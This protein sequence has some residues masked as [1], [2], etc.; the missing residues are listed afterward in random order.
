V[1]VYVCVCICVCV[2]VYMCMCVCVYVCVYMCV[3]MCVCVGVCVCVYAVRRHLLTR[4]LELW[5]GVCHCL[6]LLQHLAVSTEEFSPQQGARLFT[7]ATRSIAWSLLWQ[8][9]RLSRAGIVSKWL[10]LS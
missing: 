3:C 10:N 7:C 5:P 9:V 2:C 6:L 4:C 1:W 8:R